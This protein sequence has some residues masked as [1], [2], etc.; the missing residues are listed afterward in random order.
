MR[1][2]IVVFAAI[3]AVALALNLARLSL[4]IGQTGEDTLRARLASASSALKAQFDLLDARLSPRAAASVPELVE[5]TRTE[6]GP[7]PARPDERVLRAA[8][9]ALSPEPDLIAVATPQGAILARRGRPA[10]VL[11]N[12]GRLPLGRAAL[13]GHPAPAFATFDGATYRVAAARVPGNAAAAV[14]GSLIDDRFAA[15][16]KSQVDA[17][18]TLLQDGN[19]IASSLA[20]DERARVARWAAAPAPGYGVLRVVLPVVRADLSGK[21]PRG[22]MRF[23][24]RGALVGTDGGVQV[25]LT[26]PAS[27]YHSWLAR[28][29]AFYVVG[30]AVFV[31]FSIAWALIA[32]QKPLLAGQQGMKTGPDVEEEPS[33]P[34]AFASEAGSLDPAMAPEPAGQDR[35]VGSSSWGEATPSPGEERNAGG[36][37]EAAPLGGMSSSQ[38]HD[39]ATL[40]DTPVGSESDQDPDEPHWREIFDRFKELKARLG[41]PADRISFEKFAAKLRKNRAD[42]LAKHNCKGVR[43]SVYEK[44]GKAAIKASA[45]R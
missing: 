22:A 39:S 6:S 3:V 42:L 13:E 41:E 34:Q 38:S 10:A 35:G 5:A 44:E 30:L 11:D 37:A 16:L 12:L 9:A 14:V 40:S 43:F 18:V 36:S 27:P 24:V 1:G 2:R 4:S 33:E 17:D 7:P 23:A 28:Y 25:A 19:V 32:P 31:L 15:Q 8:A 21:L 26:I 20:A 45:I 29:Q